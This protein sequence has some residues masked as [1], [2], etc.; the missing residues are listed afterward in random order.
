MLNRYPL[1]KYLMI[2]AVISLGLVYSIPN[3]YAPDPAVQISAESSSVTVDE[4]VLTR[5]KSALK[6]AGIEAFGE[7]AGNGSALLRLNSSED[8]L[9]AKAVI[10]Q[11]L[12]FDY[13]VA[14]NLAPTTPDWLANMGAEPMKLG[15]DL[16]GGV[17]FLLQVDTK[18]ALKK[19]LDTTVQE[20]KRKLRS[21]KVRYRSLKLDDDLNIIAT[22]KNAELRDSAKGIV[23][24]NFR[25]LERDLEAENDEANELIWR[26]SVAEIDKIEDYAVSQNLTTLRN[27]VNELGV[28]EPIVQRQG[29]DRIVVQLPGVQDTAGAKRII[30]KTASLEF[31]LEAKP[32]ALGSAKEVFEFRNPEVFPRTA[33]LD[34]R[35][36]I[37]GENVID[38]FPGFDQ[39]G[40]PMVNITLDSRGG[41]LINR[42]TRDN[43]NRRMGVLF[44]EYK[45]NVTYE[46]NEGGERVAINNQTVERKLIS[47]PTIRAA[48]GVKFVIEGLD[49]P[50]E[51]SELS[52][53][54]RA[55]AL[56][57]PMY[58][59]E[60]RTIGPSLGADN[61]EMGVKSVILGLGLVLV[62]MLI[63]YKVFGIAA[64]L[65][66]AANILLL[67]GAMSILGATLTL[68]GIAGIVLTVGMAVDANVLIFSRIKEELKAGY[69][70]QQAI[71]TGF[72]RAFL[73]IVDANI[74]TLLVAIILYAVGSGPVQGF[75]VTLFIGILCSM[76]TA[77][78]GT[79]AVV[80][81]IYGG[82]NVKK[83]AI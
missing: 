19:R 63:F 41:S 4:R 58:F 59:V 43:I 42:A 56:A 79:R 15:L 7:E 51:A 47:L 35:P 49:S 3:L 6:Q 8:Q 53:L 37:K 25:E 12:G 54:L 11:A 57:A 71:H 38:A 66:L 27:R 1:W 33:E 80:N 24:I 73:T 28:S 62:F 61:I 65:A 39:N 77:I 75:A 36:I 32:D 82:R 72:D 14:L 48:L 69:S 52:L 2:L 67:M 10:Q 16:S 21:E 5:A 83:L 40:Q 60:E 30:G 22:F 74:T 44:I 68:P 18:A 31:R 17:H 23:N 55:G 76:F 13:V 70:P 64:N 9:A 45:N 46:F 50:N 26:M 34:R 20:M 78:M 81:L 29:R